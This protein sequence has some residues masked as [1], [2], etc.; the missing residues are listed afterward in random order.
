MEGGAVNERWLLPMAL[1]AL[2]GMLVWL[3]VT[4]R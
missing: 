2:G 4:G 3:A 1:L